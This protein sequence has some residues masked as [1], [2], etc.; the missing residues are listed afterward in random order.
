MTTITT[1]YGTGGGNIQPGGSSGEPDLATTLREIVDDLT[2]LRAQL[3]ATHVKLDAD[4][5]VTDADYASTLVPDA[6]KT[7]KG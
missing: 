2:E 6:L 5:G 7:I 1:E 4:A 3:I